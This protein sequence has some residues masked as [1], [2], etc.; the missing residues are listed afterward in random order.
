MWHEVDWAVIAREQRAGIFRL[1][2]KEF[3]QY[4]VMTRLELYNAGEPCGAAAIRRKLKREYNIQPL[5]S[6]STIQRILVANC[7]TNGRIGYYPGVE[8][9]P[10]YQWRPTRKERW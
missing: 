10:P 6:S 2:P 9:P 8:E 5:P 3:E 1:S 7:L 4:T